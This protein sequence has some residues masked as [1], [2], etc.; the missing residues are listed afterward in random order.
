MM[1]LR[2]TRTL[3]IGMFAVVGMVLGAT[4]PAHAYPT[5]PFSACEDSSAVSCE[6]AYTEG[7]IIW[8]NRTAGVQGHVVD[9]GIGSTTAVFEAFAG[10]TKIDSTT[11]TANDE[12]SLGGDRS[13]NF[14]IG[15]PNLVG[16]IDRVRVTV[17]INYPNGTRP[18]GTPTH[19]W[20]P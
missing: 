18:C 20:R 9:I 6:S 7:G 13:F 11:R 16:G 5:S 3:L 8:Y 14:T 10:A 12:S 19:V 1:N 17:C 2:L 15:D 4:A